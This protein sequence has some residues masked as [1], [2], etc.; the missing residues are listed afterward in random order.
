MLMKPLVPTRQLK[1][2][3]MANCEQASDVNFR[4]CCFSLN[5][6]LSSL[7]QTTWF[8]M[9]STWWWPWSGTKLFLPDKL[10]VNKRA[11][12]EYV[13]LR[14]KLCLFLLQKGETKICSTTVRYC[15][16]LHPNF[17][18]QWHADLLVIVN[19]HRWKF[20]KIHHCGLLV[21][22]AKCNFW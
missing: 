20:Y 16:E 10:E 18:N 22:C 13:R 14:S 6:L 19:R 12:A 3:G 1:N 7:I 5:F 21:S 17:Q 2:S 11:F 9:L 15:F 8:S 4:H